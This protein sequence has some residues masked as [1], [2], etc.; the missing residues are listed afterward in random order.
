MPGTD[1]AAT[2]LLPDDA[3]TRHRVVSRW[4]QR[5]YLPTRCP[6]CLPT[7]VLCDVRYGPSGC[8]YPPTRVLFRYRDSASLA[9][10]LRGCYAM[11]GTDL[12][13]TLR[14]C[15]AMSSTDL[16][17]TLR[18]LYA[19]SSTDLAI[20]LR[21]CYAMS[22]TYLAYPRPVCVWQDRAATSLCRSARDPRP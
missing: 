17:F 3:P 10:L 14:F 11:S 5:R 4:G 6:C 21:F 18:F 2:M 8:C 19:M 22:G 7:R 13:I 9:I 1:P 15:Y 12:A 16:A 20:T